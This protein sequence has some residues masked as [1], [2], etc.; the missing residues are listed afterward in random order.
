MLCPGLSFSTK[1]E[2]TIKTGFLAFRSLWN[3]LVVP[4]KFTSFAE[5]VKTPNFGI[6]VPFPER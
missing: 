4:S 1:S 3:W 5:K 6:D 2:E